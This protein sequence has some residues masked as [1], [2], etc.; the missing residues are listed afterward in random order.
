MKEAIIKILTSK[1]FEREFL[2]SVG[3]TLV[4][5]L[6]I[7]GKFGSL[8]EDTVVMV[9]DQVL[10]ITGFVLVTL[11]YTK[12]RTDVKKANSLEKVVAAGK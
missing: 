6:K 4:L 8:S 11:G 3:V 9:I 10:T 7:T 1:W 2:I 12:S 5:A